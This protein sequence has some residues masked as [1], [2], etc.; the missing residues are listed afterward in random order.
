M[1][2]SCIRT[3]ENNRY[4]QLYEWQ[5]KFCQGNRCAALLLSFFSSWHDWKIRNDQ[6]YRRANDIAEMHGDGRSNNENAYMFFTMEEFINGVMGLYGKNSINEALQLLIS[7]RV[8]SV[9]TNPNPR[10]HFDKTKYFQFYPEICN[11]W[12]ASYYNQNSDQSLQKTDLT[13]QPKQAD[14]SSENKTLDPPKEADLSSETKQ[15]S[16]ESGRPSLET[17]RYITNNTNNTTN[18]NQSINSH[19]DFVTTNKKLIANIHEVDQE[20][21]KIIDAL[22]KQGMPADRFNY[23]DIA[24]KIQ[25][26]REAGATLQQFIDAFHLAKNVKGNAFGFNY[27]A[28]IV[29]TYVTQADSLRNHLTKTINKNKSLQDPTEYKSDFKNAVSWAGDVIGENWEA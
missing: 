9:H 6:Y 10:Y 27:I 14:R 19:D 5:I 12:I 3:P 4:I 13:D 11:Q 1:K 22:K 2:T 25:Q 20:N 26:L 28:K 29:A 17:G 15:R 8:I 7:L 24:E 23:P 16:A 21:K 18:K